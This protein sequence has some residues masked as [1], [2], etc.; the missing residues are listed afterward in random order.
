MG[1]KL[2]QR[3]ST[4]PV[5]QD[6]LDRSLAIFAA[7]KQFVSATVG[8]GWQLGLSVIIPVFIGV[9]LDGKYDTTP[10]YTIAALILAVGGAVWVVSNTIK[11]VNIEQAKELTTKETK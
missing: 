8:M 3:K 5:A 2:L 6:E 9:W 10:S 4:A 1:D 11:Q 7:K